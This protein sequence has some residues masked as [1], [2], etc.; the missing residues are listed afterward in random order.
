VGVSERGK[1][2]ERAREFESAREEGKESKREGGRERE[3][4]RERKKRRREK[5][6]GEESVRGQKHSRAHTHTYTHTHL[7]TDVNNINIIGGSLGVDRVGYGEYQ[8]CLLKS[9]V[10]D[11]VQPVRSGRVALLLGHGLRLARTA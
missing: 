11:I 9:L 4:E 10:F 1:P 5:R 6:R 2:R 3:R 8:L 7:A